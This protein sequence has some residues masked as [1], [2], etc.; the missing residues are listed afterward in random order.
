MG[1]PV[2]GHPGCFFSAAITFVP[3]KTGR[4]TLTTSQQPGTQ[5]C[6]GK[7]IHNPIVICT[8]M[9]SLLYGKT[10]SNFFLWMIQEYTYHVNQENSI[11]V[12]FGTFPRVDNEFIEIFPTAAPMVAFGLARHLP[13]IRRP[14]D[15]W[16]LNGTCIWLLL[17]SWN[18]FSWDVI[19]S[20]NITWITVL[21]N[22]ALLFMVRE[23][24]Q[25]ALFTN[26]WRNA[27]Q[28]Y[29]ALTTLHQP[30][31]PSW[32]CLQTINSREGVRPGNSFPLLVG[33]QIDATT[34]ENSME[35]LQKTKNRNT[36]WSCSPTPGHLSGEFHNLKRCVH[37]NV[38]WRTV[39]NSQDLEATK[40][41]S[42]EEW[43]K[44][45]RH[46]YTVE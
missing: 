43:I 19:I 13:R 15:S 26:Y 3:Q 27:T 34:V 40:C 41:P 11:W 46:I 10:Q 28:N 8:D 24:F 37:P 14:S 5:F 44:K 39:Y 18:S 29:Y 23:L 30:E 9:P 33:M 42:T 45:M 21:L 6:T 20:W 32:K 16:W 38:H 7:K 22:L 25:N 36:I 1:T 35:L 31:W 4:T 17:T 12:L 2:G